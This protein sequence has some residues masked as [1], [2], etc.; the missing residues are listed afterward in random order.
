MPRIKA[1]ERENL[2]NRTRLDL[3]ESAARE[4]AA[5]G[6]IGANI[7]H[8]SLNAGFA[9]GTI[10]NYFP[11]K[12]ELMLALIAD[13]GKLHYEWIAPQVLSVAEPI[14]RLE[15]FYEAGFAFG[16]RHLARSRVMIGNIYGSSLEFKQAMFLAYQP[17]GGL[18]QQQ[19]L[20]PGLEQGIFR[21]GDL[22]S[23]TNLV[24]TIYMGTASNIADDGSYWIPPK[25]VAEFVLR[26]LL[27]S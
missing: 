15:K 9:K 18:V 26:G 6:Y 8:I 10:Y 7:N 2:L 3:L 22:P 24:M 1:D 13:T 25:M 20:L 27:D 5:Q 19:V 12:Q 21:Q 23:L 14:Q 11:S 16:A 17:L 4:F